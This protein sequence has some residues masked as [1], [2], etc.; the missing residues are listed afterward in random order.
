[1]TA[2]GL[3]ARYWKLWTSAGLSNLA[4]G[5]MKVA[6]PLVAIRYTDSPAIIAGLTFAFTLP[7]LLFALTAGA[8][9]DRLDRRRLMLVAN[10]ARAL[11]LA[12]LTMATLT[13]IGSI[14]MLYAAAICIGVAETVYDTSSQSILPQLV[15]RDRLSR[16]NG[17]LYAAELTANEFVG[18]P[19]GGFLVATGVALAFGAPVL[20]WLAAIGMLLL[21]R[22]H[23]RADRPERTTIR[24]DIAEG[25]RFLRGSTLLRTLAIMVGVFNFASSAV[26]TVFVL[27]AV[28]PQSAMKL[29][30][31]GY[32][33]LLTASAVGS[34][35][36]TFLAEPAERLL[37]RAR[38]LALTIVGSLLTVATPFF[39]TNPFVIAAGM[40]IGGVTVSIWNV[41][42]VSLR[43]RVT[44]TR[45]L[46]RVNSAYRLLAWGTMPLGAL[47]GG[48]IGQLFGVRWVFLVMGILVVLQLIPMLWVTD[49]RMDAAEAEVEAEERAEAPTDSP[50]GR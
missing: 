15:P 31:P 45:L 4:D 36:G 46:G 26:F 18:P 32:G 39:T 43:Q 12:F 6:L 27:Y 37:G 35:L 30:D 3:G 10:A 13:G 48:L 24:A 16:A 19:L 34:V 8:L 5:V 28:G 50:T 44:P 9:A 7:W 22:G 23:Y 21:V 14:W 38:G 40:L 33:L 47:A 41:I 17:R 29:T 20:L 1:M 25:L 2:N 42:T 11:F 49:R